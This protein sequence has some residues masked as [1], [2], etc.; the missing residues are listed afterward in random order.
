MQVARQKN[1]APAGPQLWANCDPKDVKNLNSELA[2][3]NE[4]VKGA[5]D[6]LQAKEIPLHTKRALSR[7]LTADEAKVKS[8]IL[9]KLEAI[10]AD[11]KLG[12]TNFHCQTE[13]QCNAA[14]PNGAN[15]YSGNPITLCPGYFKKETLERI[16]TLIHESGHNAGLMGNIVE[17]EWP[18]PGLGEKERLGNTES[19]AAFIRSNKIPSLAPYEY[20]LAVPVAVG[21]GAVFPGSGL[22]PR[23]LVRAEWDFLLKRRIFHF[24]DLH[25]GV[26]VNVDSAGSVLGSVSFGTRSFAPLSLTKVPVFLDLRTGIVAGDIKGVGGRPQG[27]IGTSVEAGL[28]IHSGRFG[29]SVSY[30]HIFNFLRSN[31]DINA[32]LVSGEIRFF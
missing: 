3:A 6:D 31:P 15:A 13:Q 18:F 2:Q 20:S 11:L 7:Y 21:A 12:A 17:W 25:L 32:V 9:P 30:L 28:G 8:D 27:L 10:L 1:P 24:M 23:F 29:A 5:I 14:F 19:Y 26:G 4:W 16:T 22:S